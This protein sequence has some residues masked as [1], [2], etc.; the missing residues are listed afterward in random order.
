MDVPTK[1]ALIVLVPDNNMRSGIEALL[2]RNDSLGIKKISYDI[3]IHPERNGWKDRVEVIVFEPELEIWIWLESINTAK[4]MGWDSYLELRKWLE[5]NKLWNEN[6]PKPKRPK[7]ALEQALRAK[8]IP[9]SSSIYKE[10]AET[11]S[12]NKCQEPSFKKF[13]DVL[14]NWFPI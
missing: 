10:I 11:V 12:L 8:K 7:E 6:A 14:L 2:N 4:A 13:K 5:I 1:K 9:R 3:R